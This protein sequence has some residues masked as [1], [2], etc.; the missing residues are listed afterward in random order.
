MGGFF[1]GD[2]DVTATDLLETREPSES[3]GEWGPASHST[4]ASGTDAAVFK[5][6]DWYLSNDKPEGS[7]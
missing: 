4:R 1:A 7:L 6:S 2:K 5:T 3:R